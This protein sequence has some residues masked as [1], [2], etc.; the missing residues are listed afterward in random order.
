M[1]GF[2]SNMINSLEL[3]T[4]YGEDDATRDESLLSPNWFCKINDKTLDL[5][6]KAYKVIIELNNSWYKYYCSIYADGFILF[7][8][9]LTHFE[10]YKSFEDYEKDT[11]E[12]HQMRVNSISYWKLKDVHDRIDKKYK[13][14]TIEDDGKEY[15]FNQKGAKCYYDYKKH[16][17]LKTPN[18]GE[19]YTFFVL[20]VG[21]FPAKGNPFAHP[22]ITISENGNPECF[23]LPKEFGNWVMDRCSM[24]VAFH[25]N[26][27]PC[28]VE[29]S[30]INGK[31]QLK[32]H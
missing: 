23:L 22:C 13:I 11:V 28:F 32:L 30:N 25:Q 9:L 4:S 12:Y 15:Y 6:K 17:L 8:S 26:V 3:A 24:S 1:S 2:I 7:L 20:S 10:E 18:E 21:F 29:I 27:F 14:E 31:L 5:Y 19:F 16:S